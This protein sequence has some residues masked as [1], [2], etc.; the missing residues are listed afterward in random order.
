[1]IL[2]LEKVKEGAL[3]ECSADGGGRAREL[4]DFWQFPEMG[5]TDLYSCQCSRWR[6]ETRRYL[7]MAINKTRAHPVQYQNISV[8]NHGVETKIYMQTP[9][10]CQ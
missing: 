7:D 9:C 5:Q 3:I 4:E 10:V 1:M 8:I 6:V 2:I